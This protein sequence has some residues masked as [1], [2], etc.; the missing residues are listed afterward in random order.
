MRLRAALLALLLAAAP[1]AAHPLAPAFLELVEAADGTTTVL[2]KTP[3]VS[4]AGAEIRPV[5]PAGCRALGSPASSAD[6]SSLAH[7][8]RVDCG[9]GGWAEHA[10]AVTG[11]DESRTNAIVRIVLADGRV[12]QTLLSGANA[13][14]TVPVRP[15]ALGIL[16]GYLV[17]GVEHLATGLDHLLFV[18]GLVLLLGG[19]RRLLW[20]ITSFTLGHSL[21]LSAAILG[22]VAVPARPIEVGIAASI[23]VLASE[24]APPAGTR[25]SPLSRYPWAMALAFGLLHGFGFAGA[26]F[27]I[28]LPRGEI[29]LALFAF[30]AGIELGQILFVAAILLAARLAMPRPEALPRWAPL[31]PAYVIGSLAALWCFERAVS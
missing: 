2:W 25:P 12:V 14:F 19:G 23:L 1:A 21:T 29:P 7:R 16:R 28:G 18:L 17:L 15:S 10:V 24:I 8:W 3:L 11:L 27:E 5:L 6:A 13:A 9:A 30:N 20:T 22:I 26:L 31:A 4:P